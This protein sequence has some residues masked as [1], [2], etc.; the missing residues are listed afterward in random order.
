MDPCELV[1]WDLYPS[2]SQIRYLPHIIVTSLRVLGGAVKIYEVTSDWLRNGQIPM[3][4]MMLCGIY[5]AP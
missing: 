2:T 5:V 1:V 3:I 4:Y